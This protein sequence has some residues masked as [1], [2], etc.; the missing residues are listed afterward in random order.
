M[1]KKI[2][3]IAL[4]IF[5]M[6]LS[7]LA[8]GYIASQQ[9][10]TTATPVASPTTPLT[11]EKNFSSTVVATHNTPGDCWFIVSGKVYDVTR[12]SAIHPGGAGEITSFC[13]TDATAA[14]ASERSH[15]AQN[16]TSTANELL[17]GYYIGK[18]L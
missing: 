6:G 9:T 10:T 13:G 8:G 5:F 18:L 4:V 17:S 3:T 2:V 12:F 1:T 11:T 16:A 14:Y 7:A 15:R